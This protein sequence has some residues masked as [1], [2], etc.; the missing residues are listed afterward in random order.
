MK[1][2]ENSNN[3][4]TPNLSHNSTKSGHTLKV[5]HHSEGSQKNNS[6]PSIRH[7]GTP[8]ID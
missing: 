7:V 2:D 4:E 1:R 6:L 5:N 8:T 3:P